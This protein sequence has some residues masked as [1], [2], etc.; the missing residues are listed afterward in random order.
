MTRKDLAPSRAKITQ[1]TAAE[2][3]PGYP[4][5]LD[6]RR[7]VPLERSHLPAK[8]DNRAGAVDYSL[9]PM[10]VTAHP[11]PRMEN[12]AHLHLESQES[13]TGARSKMYLLN[14][15]ARM[16]GAEDYEHLVWQD[17][18][19]KIITAVMGKLRDAGY[20]ASTRNAY[21]AALKGTARHAWRDGLMDADVFERIKDIKNFKVHAEPA[22][23]AFELKLLT[24]LAETAGNRD[25]VAARRNR[26]LIWL[27]VVTGIRREE[28]CKIQY[29]QD[30]D[31]VDKEIV[32]HGKGKKNRRVQPPE[33][34]WNEL[35]SYIHEERSEDRGALFTRYL[36]KT[37]KPAPA[38][39]S[40]DVSSINYIIKD[41]MLHSASFQS[42]KITP[43]DV[44]R[45]FTTIMHSH[46][47]NIRELQVLLGHANSST[48]ERYLRDDH[49]E[50]RDKAAKLGDKAF[51]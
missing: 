12:P 33:F 17:L 42:N 10:R 28:V 45:S 29:P 48:T 16:F 24:E 31:M 35:I 6:R 50:Y 39:K 20:K 4:A 25:L 11:I 36:R 32:I 7:P 21:M 43:H 47:M 30:F 44:R 13:S 22:G 37:P 5:P 3:M 49:A 15:V 40:L 14:N 1:P 41:A 26:L 19:P 34:L 9:P 8:L 46:G 38:F 2:S 18:T 51:N 23:R 27:M